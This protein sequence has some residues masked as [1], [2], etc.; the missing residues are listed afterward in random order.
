MIC[1]TCSND[2]PSGFIFCGYCGKPLPQQCSVCG[3]ENPA[4]LSACQRCGGQLHQSALY[5]NNPSSS[6]THPADADLPLVTGIRPSAV[7]EGE[8]RFVVVLFADIAGFTRLSEQL[9]PEEAV[10]LVNQCLDEMTRVVVQH[11]GQLVHYLGDGLLTVFGAP[12]AHE[13]DPERAIQAALE[14]KEQVSKLKFSLDVPRISLHLGLAC[15]RVV[16][17]GVGAQGR[18]EYT[19]IGSAVNLAARLE[20]A[21]GINQ[22]LVSEE[23]NRLTRHAFAF[24]PIT[25]PYL[26]GIDGEVQAF[27]LLGKLQETHPLS[28]KSAFFSPLVGRTAELA[29]LQRTVENLIDGQGG[30]VSVIGE[31][32]VGKSRLLREIQAQYL[33]AP[34]N[35]AQGPKFTWLSS[36]TLETG[37]TLRY[38]CFQAL[39]RN[40]LGVPITCDHVITP[41]VGSTSEHL[42]HYLSHLI[43]D[44]AEWTYPYL[45]KILGLP[46]PSQIVDQLSW[47]DEE[48][49]LWQ[50]ARAVQAWLSALADQKPLLLAFEDLHWM[51]SA[52]AR[53]LEQIMPAVAHKPIL[54]L[55]TFRPEPERP[56]WRL[57]EAARSTYSKYYTESW[58]QSLINSEIQRMIEGLL[59]TDLVPELALDLVT[60]R[61]DGNPLFIE[62][63]VRSM[64]DRGALVPAKNH[65]WELVQG[66]EEAAI[67]NTIQGILQARIDR[68][69]RD[70]RRV[71]QLAACIG[72]Q[73]SVR[74][75]SE[76]C[77]GME[78]SP[79]R[80]T[81]SIQVLEEASLIQL[82]VDLPQKEYKFKHNLIRETVYQSLLKGTRSQ[83]HGAIAQWYEANW[84]DEPEMPYPLLAYH[85]ERT[86]QVNKQ[87]EYFIRAGYQAARAYDNQDALT[88]FTKALAL[89]TN[90]LERYELLLEREHVCDLIG[91]RDQQRAD[92]DE[93]IKLA[94]QGQFDHQIAEA[95]YRMAIWHEG[96][97]EYSSARAALEQS[98][99]AAR[100]ANERGIEADSLHRLASVC[101]R[102]GH[103]DEAISTGQA[104]LQVAQA[105]ADRSREAISLTTLG[106]VHRTL[107]NME[108]A[109][110]CYRQALEIRQVIGDRREI[111]ISLNQLGNLHYDL[112]HFTEAL[113]HHRQSLEY[114]RMVGDRRGEA[115]S[116][117]GLGNIYLQCGDLAA[118]QASYEQ[119]LTIRQSIADRRG[120]AVALGDLGNVLLSQ[121]RTKAAIEQYQQ[122]LQ[123]LQDIGARRDETFSLTYLAR[124]FEISGDLENARL[125][126]QF[127]LDI[128]RELGQQKYAFD[129]LAGLARIALAQQDTEKACAYISEIQAHIRAQGFPL[130]EAPFLI[131]LTTIRVLQ[132]CDRDEE[133]RKVIADAKQ[134]LKTRAEHISDLALR[135]SFLEKVPEHVAIAAL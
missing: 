29:I 87:R 71:L 129:N 52:S 94:A 32:G 12:T 18:K 2:N 4:D 36:N 27:E 64:I 78:I 134:A 50:N 57:R 7:V 95:H 21:S 132:A 25:L 122:S 96:W 22:V 135:R 54:I 24:K 28:A 73:F 76:V 77:E 11:G 83:L 14:M 131:Y 56:A 124:A 60:R 62:E 92:L 114:F 112:G 123:I 75:L 63:L 133:A 88:F 82:E 69:E 97:G 17:A 6:N 3:F 26:Q 118:A 44:Q 48:S 61:T 16:A 10:M 47:M 81:H 15:G 46:I 68:L 45:A 93:L 101:W 66:W 100:R 43:P 40:A 127:A 89:I 20:Q 5:S 39:L 109:G 116:T 35:D 106:V 91:A 9:D 107:G 72:R 98:L 19:V 113:N 85:Y 115:W 119:A 53:L 23:L 67:P 37:E 130:S 1:S 125:R 103:F 121:G 42:A 65:R 108:Q 80:F 30:I 111:A 128:R 51:D 110:N 59:E 105:I 41:D 13:D 79:A 38:G 84:M 104:A 33:L 126:H 49:L 117:S 31:V 74:V 58:L 120:E 86:D 70:V 34:Q 90:P 102:Q 55:S 8:R 99:E